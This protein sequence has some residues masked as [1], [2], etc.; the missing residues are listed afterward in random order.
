MLVGMKSGEENLSLA[1][2]TEIDTVT[3]DVDEFCLTTKALISVAIDVALRSTTSPNT[4]GSYDARP[5][6][7]DRSKI[8]DSAAPAVPEKP[9]ASL[10]LMNAPLIQPALS[11]LQAALRVGGQGDE[12]EEGGK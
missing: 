10:F 11:G 7:I 12:E 4:P 6:E 2:P 8:P 5:T 1:Y 9:E 3:G